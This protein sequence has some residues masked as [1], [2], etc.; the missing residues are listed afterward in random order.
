[1]I[2]VALC[3]ILSSL[4]V[5]FLRYGLRDCIRYSK[6][7]ITI[8]LHRCTVCCFSLY[9]IVLIISPRIRFPL[10]A[11]IPHCCETFMSAL[12]VTPKSFS[13]V[14][15]HKTASPVIY[16]LSTFQ[17]PVCMHLHFPKLNNICHFAD[18]LTN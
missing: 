12:N 9:M 7:V 13:C 2:L 16:S 8:A 6:C 4:S 11:S 1:M 17:C 10:E 15:L 5:S 3:C 14:V 18:H